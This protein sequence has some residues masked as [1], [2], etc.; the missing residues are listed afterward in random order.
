MGPGLLC[1]NL[2]VKPSNQ[3]VQTPHRH[4][5]HHGEVPGIPG[6]AF[7]KLQGTAASLIKARH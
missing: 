5:R 2:E 7:W 4:H 3:G 1:F 6:A